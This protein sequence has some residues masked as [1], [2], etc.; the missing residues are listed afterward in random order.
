MIPGKRSDLDRCDSRNPQEDGLH[1]ARTEVAIWI[2]R[3][4]G[5]AGRVRDPGPECAA[6]CFVES[7]CDDLASRP[8][9]ERGSE[10][11]HFARTS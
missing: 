1:V 9:W 10:P 8:P 4:D 5:G 3:G 7:P 2:A 6:R 11:P